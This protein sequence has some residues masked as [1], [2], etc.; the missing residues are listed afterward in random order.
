MYWKDNIELICYVGDR[1]RKDI[2]WED[3]FWIKDYSDETIVYSPKWEANGGKVVV[4]KE[5]P[6][7]L[8]PITLTNEIY[9]RILSGVERN[10]DVVC[11]NS[12]IL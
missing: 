8:L 5:V 6:A 12:I 2:V 3:T 10:K 11:F 7:G 9:Y 1:G 4:D